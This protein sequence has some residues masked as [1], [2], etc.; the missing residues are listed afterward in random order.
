MIT[1]NEYKVNK[2]GTVKY[3][4]KI[5]SSEEANQYFGLFMRNIQ[6]ENDDLVFFGKRVTTGMVILNTCKLIQVLQSEH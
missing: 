2:D 6:W 5:L 1:F 3:Y 4:G